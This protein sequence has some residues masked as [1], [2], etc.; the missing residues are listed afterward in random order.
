MRIS[1]KGKAEGQQSQFIR[2]L[3]EHLEWL[4]SGQRLGVRVGEAGEELIN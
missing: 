1:K 3:Q 4:P 2:S